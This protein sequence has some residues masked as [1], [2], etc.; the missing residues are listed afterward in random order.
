VD[1]GCNIGFHLTQ[2]MMFEGE[3]HI[4]TFESKRQVAFELMA[5]VY[6]RR[7]GIWPEY[8]ELYHM[9]LGTVLAA[10][11]PHTQNSR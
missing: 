1:V 5:Q 6:H 9:A 3:K 11:T 8:L 7:G 2:F 4:V 10:S